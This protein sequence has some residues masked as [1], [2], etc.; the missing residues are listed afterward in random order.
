MPYLLVKQRITSF[1]GWYAAFKADAKAQKNAG[2]H[3]LV[4]LRDMNDSNLIICIF[5]IDS[6]EKAK[7]FAGSPKSGELS[8]ISGA[9]GPPEILFLEK[10]KFYNQELS[11]KA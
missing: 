7:E 8:E 6:L 2:L 3:D 10:V 11:V 5:K 9:V 1:E 4:I